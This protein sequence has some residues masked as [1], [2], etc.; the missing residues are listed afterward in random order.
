MTVLFRC[1]AGHACMR[2]RK[3]GRQKDGGA[4]RKESSG[5]LDRR[6]GGGNKKNKQEVHG[7]I[8]SGAMMSK[9]IGRRGVH[10]RDEGTKPP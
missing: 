7:G 8:M 2:S 1:A 3:I 9:R 6:G 10:W 4:I 5:K